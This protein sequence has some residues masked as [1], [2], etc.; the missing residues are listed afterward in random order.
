MKRPELTCL[1]LPILQI[2]EGHRDK[3]FYETLDDLL[4]TASPAYARRRQ[5]LLFAKLEDV[6]K[7]RS[8]D[9]TPSESDKQETREKEAD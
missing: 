8:W 3:A 7:E 1:F 2:L 9:D 5:K 4:S 6:A